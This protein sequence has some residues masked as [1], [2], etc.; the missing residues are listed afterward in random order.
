MV[1]IQK[2]PS[3]QLFQDYRDMILQQA[4]NDEHDSA[5]GVKIDMYEEEILRRMAW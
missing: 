5:L 2:A 4:R 1:D 3:G